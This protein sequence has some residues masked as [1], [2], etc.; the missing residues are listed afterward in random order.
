MIIIETETVIA[1]MNATE[2]TGE[3]FLLA[4]SCLIGKELYE[5][6]EFVG[7]FLMR[8]CRGCG[9]QH[10]L[11]REIGRIDDVPQYEYKCNVIDPRPLYTDGNGDQLRV[12]FRLGTL[13]FTMDCGYD[14]AEANW[15]IEIMRS[16]PIGDHEPP[17]LFDSFANEVRRLCLV[18]E[19]RRL[20]G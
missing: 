4:E 1:R 16:E 13:S 11:L 6:D 15:R 20:R 8:P 12:Q 10:T 17:E 3:I 14:L 18:E 5:S 7:T 9:S 19:Q 2:A